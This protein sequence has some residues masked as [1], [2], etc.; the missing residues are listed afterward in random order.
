MMGLWSGVGD[1]SPRQPL[2]SVLGFGSATSPS[3]SWVPMA[4]L[5]L[6]ESAPVRKPTVAGGE[7]HSGNVVARFVPAKTSPSCRWR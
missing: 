3:A 4:D 6:K 1:F 2:A 5:D 7:V